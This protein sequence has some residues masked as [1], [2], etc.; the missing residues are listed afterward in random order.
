MGFIGN[1]AFWKNWDEDERRTASV[2][3]GIAVAAFAVFTFISIFS[4]MLHWREDMSLLTDPAMMSASSEVSNMA[5]KLGF[6]FGRFLVCEC[7]GVGGFALLLMLVAAALRLF[8][9]KWRF[10]ILR[11]V[12]V[13]LS[14]A[15]VISFI[16]AYV[17]SFTGLSYAFGGGLGGECGAL[18]VA[19]LDNMTGPIVSGIILAL[20]AVMWLAFIGLRFRSRAPQ[21]VPDAVSEPAPEPEEELPAEE[22]QELLDDD[23][24]VDVPDY[25]TAP[26]PY[27]PESSDEDLDVIPGD[28]P[29]MEVIVDN[30]FGTN[31]SEPLKPI[32]TRLDPP[33]GLPDYKMPPLTLLEE[34]KSSRKT[35]SEQELALNNNRIRSALENYRITVS[36]VQ[37]VV[38]PTVTLYKVY[39]DCSRG[40]KIADVKSRQDDIA[41]ALR[42]SGVR[43]IQLPDCM[44]IEVPNDN[45][46]LVPLRSI[47]SSNAFRESRY[48]LPVAI[49]YTITQEVRVI[50]LADAPHLLIAGATKQGKSV[51]LN[52]IVN[53]LLY[54]KH[55]SEMKFV[56]IDPKMVEF[57]SYSNLYKHYLA[58]LPEAASEEDE[59]SRAI[60]KN[61]SDAEKVL[62]SLCIEMD[63]RYGLMSRAGVNKITS[64]NDK[65]C[66]HKLNP[67]H[68]HRFLPYLVVIIDEFADL[69]MATGPSPET[70]NSSRSISNSIMR[71]AQ[72]GRAAGLHLILA[73]QRPSVKIISGDM[74]GNFPV[75]IAFKTS[76][77]QDSQT[78]IDTVGAEKL[79]GKGDMLLSTGV[80]L[81][82]IQCGYVSMEE[83]EKVNAF[84]ASQKSFGKCYDHPYYLPAPP[85]NDGGKGGAVA[86]GFNED[87]DERFEEAARMIVA[88]QRASTTSLQTNMGM[89]YP[90]AARLMSQLQSAGIVAPA[91]G[92]KMREVL[93]PDMAELD[94][95]LE[96]LKK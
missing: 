95:L 75:R 82:R 84:I 60:V 33:D 63:E 93:V 10:S 19:W 3:A 46:S 68:G 34:Y 4:Y 51:G 80:T 67:E 71:L 90:A 23:A 15:F 45:P 43:V 39:L 42:S 32:D 25:V 87:F 55:P 2:T 8:V 36:D 28:A 85:D 54:S 31:N 56:F 96:N 72:K 61:A 47:L 70:K 76:S 40:V 52:V 77:H 94:I 58:V 86:G 9:R 92:A 30:T 17:S 22:P 64:Y 48:E 38:G 35:V 6:R 69:T 59:K 74:K 41:M 20:L 78:I 53:S 16:A 18:A 27:A 81:E 14:G 21:D 5:G 44:G 26:M 66:N 73:T 57:S 88:S 12:F 24:D 37:A 79:I 62:R 7:F 13:S 91:N 29:G 50:D 65:W 1:M 83:V 89:G 49:G 11:T